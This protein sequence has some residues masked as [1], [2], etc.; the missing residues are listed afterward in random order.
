M[1][2]TLPP[3]TREYVLE[4][5]QDMPSFPRV[6]TDILATVDDPDGSINVLVQCIN[7]DPVIAARVL[8][9]ANQASIRARREREVTDM[10]TATALIGMGRVREIAL[11][12]NL[13][14]FMRSISANAS[15]AKLWH[16]GVAVGICCQELAVHI[17]QTVSIDSA[18]VAGLLH[19]IGQFWLYSYNPELTQQCVAS[20]LRD[21]VGIEAAER[22]LL[23]ADHTTI[24]LWLAEQWGLPE[25]ICGAI[26]LH[27]TPEKDLQNILVPLLHV[28]EVLS[29][30]LD[31]TQSP[32]SHVTR[33]SA[34]ACKR[35]GI[36][37]DRSMRPVF[38]RIEARS[39]HANAFFV[40][41]ER[42]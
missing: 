4:H 22:Q 39:K 28:A 5:S 41:S 9:A 35:L 37:W 12:G 21:G 29:N 1:M 10:H 42:H 26:A 17:E 20:A 7:H 40:A 3:I 15:H 25:A 33:I 30:A 34:A 13:S 18:L 27:H 32:D 11:I 23:G 2:E 24:G 8:S 19:D 16:H 36:E 14:G 31:L 6:V 38:G